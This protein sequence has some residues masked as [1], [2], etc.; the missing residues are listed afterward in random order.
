MNRRENTIKRD[1]NILDV[2]RDVI[3]ELDELACVVSKSYIYEKIR[4]RTDFCTKT[5]TFIINHVDRK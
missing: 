1:N 3:N 4:E 5:I 2:Y